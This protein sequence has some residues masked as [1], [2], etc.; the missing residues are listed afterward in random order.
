MCREIFWPLIQHF[1]EKMAQKI[2]EEISKIY[3]NLQL[4]L[5]ISLKI[6][7]E[8]LEIPRLSYLR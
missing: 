7:N 8:T 1:P 2:K 5:K 3:L 4:N 6:R